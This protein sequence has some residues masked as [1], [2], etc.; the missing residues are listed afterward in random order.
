[1]NDG[2]I[3]D[4]EGIQVGHEH[5]EEG[6]TGC[7]VIIC[8][9][10]AVG[11]V[12]VRGSAPGTRETDLFKAEKMVDRVHAVVL[13]GGSAFGLE[14]ASG[15]MDFLE[16][17]GIGF[18]TGVTKVPIVASAVIFDLAIGDYRIRPDWKM[19]YKAASFASVEEKRQGNIG[20]GKGATVGK[21][22]GA[23]SAMKSGIGSATVRTGELIVSAMICVNS[24]GD[25]FENG[26][27]IAG[28]YN[29][30][31]KS[32]VNTYELMKTMGQQIGFPNTNTTIGVV[33][34]NA[35]LTK[36]QGN[37]IAQTS[38]N[39]LAR[40]ISPVHTM[41]DG[42]T[43]FVMGTNKVDADIN[44]VSAMSVEAVEKAIVNA[45]KSAE[46][47]GGLNSYKDIQKL[48]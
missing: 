15:V 14:A 11:G 30:T 5:S 42:D 45:I 9:E 26:K 6:M 3:T 18:D 36:A 43:M 41:V 44:L 32:L 19:G 35:V 10:G 38:H 8:P 31:S 4:V 20:C 17:K 7:T 12:D 39:G 23:A 1:M 16:E 33:V 24:F 28:P 27:Q 2:Y 22:M 13:S 40:T 34:T 29:E 47:A 48:L 21:I 25:V 37:K 46:G